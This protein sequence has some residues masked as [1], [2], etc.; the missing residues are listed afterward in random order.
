VHLRTDAPPHK[1]RM[2]ARAG[3]STSTTPHLGGA[4]S[5]SSRGAHVRRPSG[6]APVRARGVPQTPPQRT[7]PAA[8]LP[9]HASSRIAKTRVPPTLAKAWRRRGRAC[10]GS[11]GEWQDHYCPASW[12]PAYVSIRQHTSAYVG[13]CQHTPAHVSIRQHT[14]AYVKVTI[15]PPPGRLIAC[16]RA[17][18]GAVAALL[19]PQAAYTGS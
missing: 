5:S 3:S 12:A 15:A 6:R 18:A 17:V 16:S 10:V 19:K 11:A 14:S 2:F 7:P 8:R 13:I 1:V 9:K 4:H